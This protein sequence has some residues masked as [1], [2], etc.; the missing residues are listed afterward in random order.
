MCLVS[1]E[2]AI[3]QKHRIGYNGDRIGSKNPNWKG[4]NW[5]TD[6]YIIVQVKLGDF[7]YPMA[8]KNGYVLEHRLVMAKH[9][10]RCLQPWEM[11]H[12]KDGIRNHNEYTNLEISTVG[13]H[14]REHSKGYRDGYAKGLQ[15]GRDSQIEEL[16]KEIRLLRWQIN[17]RIVVGKE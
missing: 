11:V 15:D 1:E 13:S 4:G 3:S 10:G 12:H 16:R 9:L 6:G 8:Q 17:E 5:T 14:I 2:K 7:F